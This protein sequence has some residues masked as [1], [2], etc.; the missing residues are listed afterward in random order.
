[1]PR[2]SGLEEVRVIMSVIFKPLRPLWSRPGVQELDEHTGNRQAWVHRGGDRLEGGLPGAQLVIPQVDDSHGPC[3][4]HK[5][6]V[7]CTVVWL[8]QCKKVEDGAPKG[9]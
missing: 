7:T 3:M 1:M 4:G 8:E 5:L 9:T 2:H 6:T